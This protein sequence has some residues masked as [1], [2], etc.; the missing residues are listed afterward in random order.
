VYENTKDVW[1]EDLQIKVSSKDDTERHHAMHH[2]KPKYHEESGKHLKRFCDSWIDNGQ[3]YYHEF[4]RIFKDLK[5]S[6]VWETLQECWKL[7]HKKVY[8]RGHNQDDDLRTP[9]EECAASNKDDWQIDMPDGDEIDDIEEASVD[10]VP[11]LPE[12]KKYDNK[13]YDHI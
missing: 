12:K 2:N 4:F 11:R 13:A 9:E 7:Y 10:N 8:A 1:E 6:N 5:S 3:D